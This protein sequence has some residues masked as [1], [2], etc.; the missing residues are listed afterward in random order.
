MIILYII[1]LLCLI[2]GFTVAN[3]QGS[4][5]IKEYKYEMFEAYDIDLKNKIVLVYCGENDKK[6]LVSKTCPQAC[7][8]EKEKALQTQGLQGLFLLSFRIN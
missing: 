6:Y 2:L 5:Q 7:I 1:T 3:K 4:N 8:L